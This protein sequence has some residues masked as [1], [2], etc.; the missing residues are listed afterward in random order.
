MSLPS[1]ILPALVLVAATLGIAPG[2]FAQSGASVYFDSYDYQLVDLNPG[3]G[4][5]PTIE[6][7]SNSIS[8]EA[9]FFDDPYSGGTPRDSVSSSN[10]SGR[11][12]VLI[13]SEDAY[14]TGQATQTSGSSLIGIGHGSGYMTTDSITGFILA[15]YTQITFSIHGSVDESN[16]P[17]SSSFATLAMTGRVYGANGNPIDT[18]RYLF[19]DDGSSSS[20]L[21]VTLASGDVSRYGQIE[22]MTTAAAQVLPVPEPGGAAMLMGGLGLMA[23]FMRRRRS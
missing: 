19:S 18:N 23:A 12:N 22:F 10:P 14:L 21:T 2:A 8:G 5:A 11:V 7:Y 16:G 17:G 1:R 15:P 3:D 13:D 9:R 6:F 20:T 4:I